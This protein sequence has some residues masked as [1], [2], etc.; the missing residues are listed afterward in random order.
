MWLRWVRRNDLGWSLLPPSFLSS[1]P[2]KTRASEGLTVKEASAGWV[3]PAATG[4][5]TA[6][7][8]LTARNRGL[9]SRDQ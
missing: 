7:R 8:A 9:R 2:A 6:L 1:S 3:R 4:E 5:D